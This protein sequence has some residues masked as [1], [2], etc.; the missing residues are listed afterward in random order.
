[1][2]T[3]P[4]KDAASA[5][6][7]P[8]PI[9]QI[10]SGF[11]AAKMLFVATEVGVFEGLT[12]GPATEKELANRLALP[13]STLRILC[14]AMAAL[15]ILTQTGGRYANT[16]A[17]AKY[18]SGVDPATDLRPF[19]RMRNR[20]S[21]P[22]WQTLEDAVRSGHGVLGSRVFADSAEQRL[23]AE[24][25]EGFTKQAARALT[26]SYDF[27]IHK[28]AIDLGGG[29][30]IFLTSIADKYA[31]IDLALFE[32][33]AVSALARSRFADGP[34]EPRIR[35]IDGDFLHDPI[36]DGYDV[37]ILA[38]VLHVLPEQAN[39]QLMRRIREGAEVGARLLLVDFFLNEDRTHPLFA[40]LMSGEFLIFDGDG[41]SY[42][43]AE[44]RTWLSD[45]GWKPLEHRPLGGPSSLLVAEAV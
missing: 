20:F 11:M 8:D 16:P 18:L 19:M 4:V 24:G 1:M 40:A 2:Q 15:G 33:P 12:G 34:Y 38:N 26:T 25:V 7:V 35:V 13:P 28:R 41:R 14:D 3:A 31:D 17:A 22:R 32:L 42:S 27:S 43:E 30:G 10:A 23:H 45:T 44:C 9:L 39:R 5:D 29:I 6:V 37:V 36:P 21:Y